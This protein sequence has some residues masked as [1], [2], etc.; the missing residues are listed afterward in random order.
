MKKMK[1]LDEIDF[2]DDRET[3]NSEQEKSKFSELKKNPNDVSIPKTKLNQTPKE[4]EI[5]AEILDRYNQQIDSVRNLVEITPRFLMDTE[6]IK[7][8]KKFAEEFDDIKHDT[9]ELNERISKKS[10]EIAVMGLEKTGKTSFVNALLGQQLLPTKRER[11]TYIPTEIRSGSS[12][13]DERIEI[14]YLTTL[15]FDLILKEV[16]A[17]CKEITRFKRSR[18]TFK[19]RPDGLKDISNPFLSENNNDNEKLDDSTEKAFGDESVSSAIN[20][21]DEYNEIVALQSESRK[22]L[23]RSKQEIYKKDKSSNFEDLIKETVSDPKIARA[24]KTVVIYTSNLK[25]GTDECDVVLYDVPGYDSTTIMHKKQSKENAKKADVIIFVKKFESPS[26]KQPESE[27]LKIFDAVD[28]CVPLRDKLM[29]AITSVDQADS[30][31]DFKKTMDSIHNVFV[32]KNIQKERIFP[33][34]SAARKIRRTN[35]DEERDNI[36]KSSLAKLRIIGVNDGIDK[37]ADY[38]K[39]FVSDICVMNL[40]KKFNQV[41]DSLKKKLQEFLEECR[42]QFS[43][44]TYQ[45]DSNRESFENNRLRQKMNWWT[46]KWKS[47]RENF[48]NFFSKTIYFRIENYDDNLELKEPCQEYE[49]L[50]DLREKYLTYVDQMIDETKEWLVTRYDDIWTNEAG[51]L[52]NIASG[53]AHSAVRKSLAEEFNKKISNLLADGLGHIVWCT[54]NKML[55]FI[56]SEMFYIEEIQKWLLN[57]MTQGS[58]KNM[59]N[60]NIKTLILRITRPAIDLFL[61]YPRHDN[62]KNTILLYKN[63][64]MTLDMFYKDEKC[65]KKRGLPFFLTSETNT[66]KYSSEYALEFE[67]ADL[68][69]PKKCSNKKEV[70]AEINEDIE[71][72]KNYLKYSIY[73]ASGIE[74][75]FQQEINEISN[76]FKLEEE[77]T[78]GWQ[79]L[80][81]VAIDDPNSKIPRDIIES[82]NFE[83]SNKKNFV[84]RLK[85][86]DEFTRKIPFKNFKNSM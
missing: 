41:E 30:S 19:H 80:V 64:V 37:L 40:N 84:D 12:V 48:Q 38:I 4:K 43:I 74:A 82:F 75:F 31:T 17:K 79:Y 32:S 61:R 47:L 67:N 76:K 46:Q 14:V 78:R 69:E 22:Y 70:L 50:R 28:G 54:I 16:E 24:V 83:L 34:C 59:I 1:E 13:N 57:D 23:D 56:T 66:H 77:N 20:W 18:R 63:D 25:L 42:S 21:V 62:R 11:C 35:K 81:F 60:K 36:E 44:D 2:N 52:A 73:Y 68:V 55:D 7:L 85:E 33:V 27:M 9:E 15:E 51:N 65:E 6:K 26:L 45:I 49:F 29:V 86:V 53:E 5:L 58:Y 72:F 8:F 39:F 10:Y 3:R 71:E